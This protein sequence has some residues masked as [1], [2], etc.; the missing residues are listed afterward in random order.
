MGNGE[1]NGSYYLVFRVYVALNTLFLGDNGTIVDQ[2]LAG[3]SVS[4][5]EP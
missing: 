2:G 5:P 1:E 4:T 3:F